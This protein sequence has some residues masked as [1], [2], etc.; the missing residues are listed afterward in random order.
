MAKI[1]SIQPTGGTWQ[2]PSGDT[3][4][5]IAY[6]FDDGTQGNALSKTPTSRFQVGDEVNVEQKG[7]GNIRINKPNPN[8]G[9]SGGK[10]SKAT[11][12]RIARSVAFKGAIDLACAGKIEMAQISATTDKLLPIVK[13]EGEQTTQAEHFAPP[14]AQPA[15]T[16]DALPL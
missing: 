2:S 6:T 4:H 10:N 15:Q 3:F 13:G 1:T 14:Q 16:A 5:N 9:F 11:E 12:E 8:G 7:N